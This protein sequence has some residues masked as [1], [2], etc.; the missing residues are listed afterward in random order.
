[1]SELGRDRDES[2]QSSL[3]AAAETAISQCM[4][5]ESGESCVIMADD[6]TSPTGEALYRAASEITEEALVAQYPPGSQHG[7]EPP[8]PVA[9]AM[10]AAD[11]VLCPTSKSLSHTRARTDATD[12]GAR[13]ATLPG[14]TEEIFTTGLDADYDRIARECEDVRKQVADSEELR[15]T[16]PQ[17]TDFTVEPGTREWYSDTGIVHESGEM[18]NLPAGEVFVSPET[19]NGTYV[20]DGTMMPYG[21]VEEDLEFVVEDGIVSEVSGD[22]VREQL[23]AAAEEGGEDAFNLA[24]VG[25]G[26]N[27]AVSALV[28]S[29]LADEK[30][31]GTVHIAIGDDAGIGGDVS[32]PIHTDGVLREPTVYADGEEVELPTI[33][34]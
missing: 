8:S 6:S 7:E 2:S 5:L 31:A 32:A 19:S 10:Q 20:V 30:A 14:I 23:E 12:A 25:I 24:E 27:V 15:I 3:A 9:A 1:M 13:V 16:S 26:T 11:V 28:G 34:Q 18:S 17:G 4:A 29:V 33:E 22:A 21:L